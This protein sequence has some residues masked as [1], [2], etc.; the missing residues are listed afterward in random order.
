MATVFV[1]CGTAWITDLQLATQISTTFVI[2]WGES[3]G[4]VSKA[5]FQIN[6]EAQARVT[7]VTSESAFNQVTWTAVMTASATRSIT[8]A[9]LFANNS[10]GLII[11]GDFA[12]LALA[13]NDRISFTF[14]LTST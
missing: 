3:T 1:D 14:T 12:T 13:T 8:Q 5:Q 7:G 10:G 4:T 2:G 6:S 9:G 11:V